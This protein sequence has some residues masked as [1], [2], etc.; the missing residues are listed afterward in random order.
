LAVG[1]AVISA[2]WTRRVPLDE[3]QEVQAAQEHGVNVEK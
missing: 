2:R 1:W 3:E